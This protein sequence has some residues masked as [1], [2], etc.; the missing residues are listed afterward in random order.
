MINAKYILNYINILDRSF[1]EHRYLKID[2]E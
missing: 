1:D 2:Y